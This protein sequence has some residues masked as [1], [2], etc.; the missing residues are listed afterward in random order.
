MNV[1]AAEVWLPTMAPDCLAC[2]VQSGWASQ[3][4]SKFTLAHDSEPSYLARN[5]AAIDAYA[6]PD[7][8]GLPQ[9]IAKATNTT[10]HGGGKRFDVGSSAALALGDLLARKNVVEGCDLQVDAAVLGG[11]VTHDPAGTARK[12]GLQLAGRLPTAAETT[13]AAT[14]LGAALRSI[15]AD[16]GFGRFIMRSF[17]DTFLTARNNVNNYGLDHF[18][19]DNNIAPMY[20]AAAPAT[21]KPY[22]VGCQVFWYDSN[23]PLNLPGIDD[24]DTTQRAVSQSGM[25]LARYLITGGR[26]I[27]ELLTADYMMLNPWSA[28]SFSNS[29]D[30]NILH[31]VP[32]HNVK[33]PEEFQPVRLGKPKWPT[34]G[35][36]TELGFLTTFSTTA[37]NRN[38][39]R[40]H[41]IYKRYLGL[42]V[43]SLAQ[44]PSNLNALLAASANNPADKPPFMVNSACTICHALI[45][46]VA[47]NFAAYNDSINF[48]PPDES[49]DGPYGPTVMFD[50]GFEGTA[51]PS[52]QRASGPRWLAEQ[53]VAD[54]RFP[55]AMVR[56]WYAIITGQ[57]PLGDPPAA[58]ANLPAYLAVQRYQ[59]AE[60]TRITDEVVA[61]GYNL[62]VA[63]VSILQSPFYRGWEISPGLSA[64]A[65]AMLEPMVNTRWSGP[66]LL[67]DKLLA[68]TGTTLLSSY[69]QYNGWGSLNQ[70]L[71]RDYEGLLGGIDA[72]AQVTQLNDTP[73]GIKARIATLAANQVACQLVAAEFDR[74][75]AERRLLSG[76]QPQTTL[77]SAAGAAAVKATLA[78]AY[79]QV[80]GVRPEDNQDNLTAAYALFSATLAESAGADLAG[81]C[82]H[83]SIVSD[84]AGTIHAWMATLAFILS[85]P[86]VLLQ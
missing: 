71:I 49:P 26:D 40:A 66:D 76:V 81:D 28:R 73:T 57:E 5:L 52:D 41:F 16:D 78:A 23:A 2:H 59:D 10:P 31:A 60:I 39:K 20:C 30:Y 69:G 74:P 61:A 48:S 42:D 64:D 19:Y 4:G 54:P 13:T 14:D 36:M 51:E 9:I 27:R 85:D 11:L 1:F 86:Q 24:H 15:L 35:M 70:P 47:Q 12:V 63:I 34:V 67:N 25:R 68:T 65:A 32:W 8:S 29:F 79:Q 62:Q 83:G 72:L 43:L 80:T 21:G 45:D 77:D 56:W 37:T 18:V 75:D 44:R 46:P 38:R 3:Q 82:Q 84:D 22:T 7:D 6:A 55:R 50:A 17:D 33:D 58:T 53:V